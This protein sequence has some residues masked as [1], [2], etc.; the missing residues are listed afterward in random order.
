MDGEGHFY[1][2]NGTWLGQAGADH[3]ATDRPRD[4]A[5]DFAAAKVGGDVEAKVVPVQPRA[6]AKATPT[7]TATPRPPV[8]AAAK[9]APSGMVEDAIKLLRRLELKKTEAEG[10]VRVALAAEPGRE[11]SLEDLVGEALRAMP[12]AHLA[13]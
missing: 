9:L 5:N 10:L 8:F 13:G 12:T 7:P 2:K 3:K 11:W 4:G 1:L 6:A